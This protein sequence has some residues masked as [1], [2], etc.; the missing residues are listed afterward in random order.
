VL[1]GGIA[2]VNPGCNLRPI[3]GEPSFLFV[4]HR[5]CTL[6]EL[7]DALAGAALDILFNQVREFGP[8]ATFHGVFYS[9]LNRCYDLFAACDLG[10][11]SVDFMSHQASCYFSYL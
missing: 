11:L 10:D 4:E 5:N 9:M 2:F 3:L 6:H 1:G 7:I 8:K